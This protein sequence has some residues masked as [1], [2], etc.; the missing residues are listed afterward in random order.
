MFDVLGT[1]V[2]VFAAIDRSMLRYEM[3]SERLENAQLRVTQAQEDYNYAVQRY[4]AQ[5]IEAERALSR[6]ELAHGMLSIAQQRAALSMVMISVNMMVAIERTA[7]LIKKFQEGTDSTNL[8]SRAFSWLTGIFKPL[9]EEQINATIA[10]A[11]NTA[12]ST[13]NAVAKTAEAGATEVLTQAQLGLNAAML[14]NPVLIVVA[15]LTALAAIFAYL[16]LPAKK[17]EDSIKANTRA[18][19]EYSA[20]LDLATERGRRF[21]MSQEELANATEGAMSDFVRAVEEADS[22]FEKTTSDIEQNA[23]KQKAAVDE[24]YQAQ[25]NTI[26]DYY[27]TQRD[28]LDDQ[29]EFV[30]DRY[31]EQNKIIDTTLQERLETLRSHYAVA[32]QAEQDF[33]DEMAAIETGQSKQNRDMEITYLQQKI[34]LQEMHDHGLLSEKAYQ[35]RMHALDSAYRESRTKVN[36]RWR[37]QQLLAERNYYDNYAGDVAS[38]NREVATAEADARDARTKNEETYQSAVEGIRNQMRDNERQRKI[39]LKN[40]EDQHAKDIKAINDQMNKDLETA[41]FAHYKLLEG[42]ANTYKTN[43]VNIM[44]GIPALAYPPV[45]T[46][47]QK[48]KSIL[49]DIERMM[50]L[51][52]ATPAGAE[53]TSTGA[54]RGTGARP[55]A[56]GGEGIAYGPT[57]FLAGEAGAEHYKFTPLVEVERQILQTRRETEQLVS[58]LHPIIETSSTQQYIKI[59]V[60]ARE[61]GTPP[62]GE[63]AEKPTL[64]LVGEK[65]HPEVVK[66]TPLPEIEKAEAPRALTVPYPTPFVARTAPEMPQLRVSLEPPPSRGA[67]APQTVPG[68]IEINMYIDQINNP[69]DEDRVAK[70][71]GEKI[72]SELYRRERRLS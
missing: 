25:V 6:L 38:Y 36:D 65:G 3:A 59:P 44:Q 55:Y 8:L 23:A 20:A 17:T 37:L 16:I 43:L 56:G 45:E 53:V 39:D 60:K 13:E 66:I 31:E 71:V 2:T 14:A 62:E 34:K 5:S 69:A 32:L 51:L 10:T 19:N 46:L 33:Q 57:L 63:L 9:T 40:L 22:A 64:F 30:K 18:M 48:V 1:G 41:Q 68:T 4:G 35:D 58:V 67:A 42:Y 52:T 61:R 29:L 7:S 24:A 50:A 72:L 15:G 21:A 27:D 49:S 12:A 26:N 11:A 54:I 28:L 70:K 47:G